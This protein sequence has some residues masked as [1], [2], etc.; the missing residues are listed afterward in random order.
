MSDFKRQHPVAAIARLLAILRQNLVTLLVVAFVGSRGDYGKQFWL[1]FLVSIALALVL[2]IAGWWRFTYRLKD[3]ELQIR[4]GVFVRKNLYLRKERIQVIDITEGLV[5]RIFGL[6]KL[7]IKTAGGGTESAT[8]SA[9]SRDEAEELRTALRSNTVHKSELEDEDISDFVEE[10]P[11]E[12]WRLTGRDLFFA[13]LT[14]GNFGLIAA[15]L[16]AISGQL[17]QFITEE[18]LQYL[19]DSIPGFNHVTVI[20]TIVLLIIVVSWFLSFLGV[21]FQYADF[22]VVKHEHEMVITSGLLERKHTTIPFN[23]IQAIRFVEGIIRQPLG[24][25]MLYVESAGFEQ[26]NKE[27]SIVLLPFVR[28]VMLSEFL[29]TMLPDYYIPETETTPPKRTVFRYLRRP[30]YLLLF[31]LPFA[32][33]FFEYGWFLVFGLIP[34]ALLG[35]FRYNDA[36]L[37]FTHSIMKLQYRTLG[38]TTALVKK[39]RVQVSQLTINP[40]QK[41]KKL[42]SLIITAASGAGGMRFEIMDLD[43]EDAFS[44]QKWCLN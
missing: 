8:I 28:K 33:Y 2:G 1:I 12:T 25:G 14:S 38:K 26:K 13:A 11:L 32:W 5:Q 40:F 15:I 19:F 30:N 35:W 24:Y 9:L 4:T 7:E 42:A 31:I 37:S 17:N 34:L 44:A 36:G 39:N 20:V 6:V 23:R 10:L 43:E 3:D 21:I 41:R 18:T 27:R 16:G 22:K 29:K